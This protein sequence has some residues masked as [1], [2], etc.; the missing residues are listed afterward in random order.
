M[1]RGQ[2]TTPGRGSRLCRIAT[3]LARSSSLAARGRAWLGAS[4]PVLVLL[5]L[6]VGAGAGLGAAAFRE[7]IV[8]VTHL[9]TGM[10]DYAA[11]GAA[12]SPRFPGSGPGSSCSRR[13]SAA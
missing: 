2:T 3:V 13:C 7:I 9:V 4:S 6:I 11:A 10:S 1:V 8:G 12:P 5:A